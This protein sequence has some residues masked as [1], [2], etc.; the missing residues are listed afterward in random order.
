MSYRYDHPRPAVTVDVV[1][2]DTQPRPARV[3]LVRRREPP[4]RDHWA[5]PGGF[6]DIDEPLETA[7]GRE[8]REETGIDA[9]ALAQLGAFGRPDR[10][11]RGRVISIAFVARMDGASATP[12]RPG[13]DAADAR[14]FALGRL[15]PLAFD[16]ADIIGQAAAGV[17]D[18]P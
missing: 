1:A 14:W 8:L 17:G 4:F 11:P 9:I 15:P 2:I 3:L 13:S 6:V 5:L 10:D 7:A 12:P 18:A 16:H